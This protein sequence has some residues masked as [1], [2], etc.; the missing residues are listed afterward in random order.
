MIAGAGLLL[1]SRLDADQRELVETVQ[2]S[3]SALLT[4]INDILDYSRLESNRLQL[5]TRPFSLI[6]VPL[7]EKTAKFEQL[8]IYPYEWTDGFAS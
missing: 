6:Q 1:D 5:H 4:I 8:R 7:P 2:M 3:G